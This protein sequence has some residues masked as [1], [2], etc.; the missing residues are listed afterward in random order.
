MDDVR[1]GIF[2]NT[3]NRTDKDIKAQE[4]LAYIEENGIAAL[5]EYWDSE[6]SSIVPGEDENVTDISEWR[7]NY[8]WNYYQMDDVQNGIFHGKVDDY[9]DEILSYVEKMDNG[10]TN[11]ER[12]GCVVVDKQLADILQV[13]MDKYTFK[14]VDHSWTKLCYYYRYLGY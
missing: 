6:F 2:H 13:L 11:P 12:Q 8:F 7:F 10:S 9:T 5:K 1:N 4:Y 14:G 3:D